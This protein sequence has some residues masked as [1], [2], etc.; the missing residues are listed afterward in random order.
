MEM[1]KLQVRWPNLATL[2]KS[3]AALRLQTGSFTNLSESMTMEGFYYKVSHMTFFI[4]NT[5]TQVHR[6]L[7]K[8]ANYSKYAE[9]LNSASPYLSD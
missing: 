6:Q 4:H 3:S 1:S 9:A 5:L 2:N 7:Y 8:N